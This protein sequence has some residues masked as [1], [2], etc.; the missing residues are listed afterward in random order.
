LPSTR[1]TLRVSGNE[2]RTQSYHTFALVSPPD[3]AAQQLLDQRVRNAVQAQ[4]TGKGLIETD[5]QTADL[6]VGYG[7]VDRTHNVVSLPVGDPA[8]A[9][10]QI[11]EAVAKLFTKYPPSSSNT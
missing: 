3:V 5:R 1:R 10:R 11:D 2:H 4:L 7:M 6:Y 8:S 9:T